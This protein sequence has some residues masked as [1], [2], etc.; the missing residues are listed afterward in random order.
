MTIQTKDSFGDIPHEESYC[1]ELTPNFLE[2]LLLLQGLELPCRENGEPLQYLELGYGQGMSLNVHAAA[3]EGEF[4]GTDINPNSCN[5]ACSVMRHAGTVG[6][7]LNDSFEELAQ[8]SQQGLLPQFDMIVLH[9]VW[10]WITA[11]DREYILQIISRNVKVGGLVYVSYNCMPGWADF[12]P[13]RELLTSHAQMQDSMRGS[14]SKVQDAYGFL[15]RLEQAG[16]MIFA[17]NPSVTQKF[18]NLASQSI[19]YVAHEYFSENWY[20]PYFKNVA[21]DFESAKCSFVTSTRL[22]DQRNFALPPD[23]VPLLQDIED[24]KLRETVRDY[25]L[26]TQYRSDIFVKGTANVVSNEYQLLS[27]SFALCM[28]ESSISYTVDVPSGQLALK[29]ELYG[30]LVAFLASD[31]YSPKSI[32]QIRNLEAYTELEFP[33]ILEIISVL[34]GAGYIHPTQT[35]TPETL[36]RSKRLNAYICSKTLSGLSPMMLVSPVFGGGV[37][38]SPF[39]QLFLYAMKNGHKSMKAQAQ[40]AQSVL[41]NQGRRVKKDEMELSDKEML[42]VIMENATEFNKKRLPLL[43][44]LQVDVEKN[45]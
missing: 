37:M 43:Q 29:E 36:L 34:L 21:A 32:L 3:N 11:Q 22:L 39:E 25:I 9:G 26:N 17:R 13:L 23:T 8:K 4:W 10:S 7:M 6:H 40:F 28:L 42:A 2:S 30:P 33:A 16:A 5:Y 24:V 44:A 41:Q 38:V 27:K 18:K 15:A 45:S 14:V 31:G 12:M 19:S 35:V 20:A 1:K